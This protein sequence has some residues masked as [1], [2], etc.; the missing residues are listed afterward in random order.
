MTSRVLRGTSLFTFLFLLGIT[1]CTSTIFKDLGTHL[2]APIAVAVNPAKLRAYVVNS[3]NNEEFTG[4]SL[5]ILDITNPASPTLLG[6][7]GHPISI[8]NFSGQIYLDAAAGRLFT[9][10]RL[11]S[12]VGVVNDRLLKITIDE[13][14]SSFGSVETITVGENPFGVACCD[15]SGRIYVVN[16]GGTLQVLNPTTLA[17]SVQ[18]SL[19]VTLKSGELV[20]GLNSNEVVLLKTQGFVTNRTGR[21]YVV[22][23]GEVGDTSKNPIDLMILNAGDARGIATDGTSL[24][25]VDGTAKAGL[26]RIINPA[27]LTPVSPDTS[28]VSEVDVATIQTGTVAVGEDPNEVVVFKGKAYVSNRGSNSVSAIDIASKTVTATIAV[29]SE[30]FG[31][32]A[33]TVGTSDFLYVTN[34]VSNSISVINLANNTVV[35][36]FAP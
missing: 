20:T 30:P 36:T 13:A 18:V 23:T 5:S 21:I 34:L 19:R 1:Q 22:N 12:T 24:F 28:A 27:T 14:A 15:A 29:G 26:L 6:R 17:S 25:V 2:A 11:S 4:A 9:P 7:S 35:A 10:N 3:N 8:D 33:F 31:L 32:A 16:T